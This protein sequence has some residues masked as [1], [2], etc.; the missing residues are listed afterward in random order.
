MW[1][2]NFQLYANYLFV[3]LFTVE[4][5]VK[6]YALGIQV[7]VKWGTTRSYGWSRKYKLKYIIKSF[8][9]FII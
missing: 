8:G 3:V 7:S 6:M 4:M 5:L 9:I 2:E 1:L